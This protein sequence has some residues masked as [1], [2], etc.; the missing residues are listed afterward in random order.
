[1]NWGCL[2]MTLYTGPLGAVLYVL[3][4]QEP[5]STSGPKTPARATARAS[6]RPPKSVT[7]LAH[8]GLQ[9]RM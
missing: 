4:C 6:Q 9:H 1:M 8:V 2:L 7:G 5:A 3:S